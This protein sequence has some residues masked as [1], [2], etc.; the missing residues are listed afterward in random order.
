MRSFSINNFIYITT[1]AGFHKQQSCSQSCN[2]KCRVI[3]SSKNINCQTQ[4]Q[5]TNSAYDSTAY[6][7]EVGES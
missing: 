7:L 6:N 4:K 3:K 2:Q 1:K 5:D